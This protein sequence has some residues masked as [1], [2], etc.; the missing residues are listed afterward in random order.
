VARKAV[1]LPAQGLCFAIG[2]DTAKYVAGWLIKDGKIRR[3]HIGVGGQNVPVSRRLM[4]YHKLS[5]T[6]GVLV[7]AVSAGSPAA[8][9]DVREGDGMVEFNGHPIPSIDALHKLLTDDQIGGTAGLTVL[10]GAEKLVLSITPVE[11][12]S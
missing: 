4:Y 10:R 12:G 6:S 7:I 11:S 8:R 2:I 3:S 5:A 1:V 9:A